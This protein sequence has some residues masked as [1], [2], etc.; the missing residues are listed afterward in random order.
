MN[1]SWLRSLV[2]VIA[3]SICL[4]AVASDSTKVDKKPLQADADNA[5]LR[6]P[7]GFGAIVVIPDAGR[8]RHIAVAPNGDIY[9]KL[10]RL[11]EGKGILV[12]HEDGNGK[13]TV[14][15][16]FGDYGGT[17]IAIKNGYLYASSNEDVFRYKLDA[18][19]KVI[20]ANH[21]EKII[22]GLWNRRQ[23]ESKS[24]TLDN[25]GN[26]YVNIGAPSNSCQMQDRAVASMGIDPC[27]IL[28]S[29]AAIWQ[30][31][32]DKLNQSYADG[33]RYCTGIRNIVGLDWNTDVNELYAM[34]H[35]RDDLYRMFPTFYDTV[36]GA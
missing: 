16:S 34:M 32:A 14:V 6:L 31:K 5:G 25:A 30:F 11:K 17:G 2:A 28:D 8:A 18:N 3:L 26:I 4:N 12:L 22:S 29:A 24:I 27:P 35:G 7:K 9:V 10:E 23:H 21:P 13:A 36:Q 20:D 15:H 1:V 33:V 19:N